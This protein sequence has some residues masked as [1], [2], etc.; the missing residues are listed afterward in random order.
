M[1]DIACAA[2]VPVNVK[3]RLK[4]ALKL[5]IAA[6]MILGSGSHMAARYLSAPPADTLSIADMSDRAIVSLLRSGKTVALLSAA[7]GETAATGIAASMGNAVV[8]PPID[9]FKSD[10]PTGLAAALEQAARTLKA[11]GFRGIAFV[12]EGPEARRAQAQVAAKL[13]H[14]WAG[15]R[16]RVLDAGD[17]CS[18]ANAAVAKARLIKREMTRLDA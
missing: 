12:G 17:C 7:P 15:S 14:E 13:G 2:R 3:Q 4:A 1:S 5:T 10:G 18:D 16:I 9:G 8:G 11:K 6:T